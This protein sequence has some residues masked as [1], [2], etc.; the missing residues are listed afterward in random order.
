MNSVLQIFFFLFGVIV[1]AIWLLIVGQKMRW[2]WRF[3]PNV[4]IGF[5]VYL[6]GAELWSPGLIDKFSSQRQYSGVALDAV[7]YLHLSP[8]YVQLNHILAVTFLATLVMSL[9]YVLTHRSGE[10]K[11]HRIVTYAF[12]LT[13]ITF[14]SDQVGVVPQSQSKLWIFPLTV[15]VL[16]WLP[17]TSSL[18]LL[19]QMQRQFA[20]VVAA[21]LV[22]LV[23]YPHW[24]MAILYNHPASISVSSLAHRSIRFQG[25]TGHPNTMGEIG[26]LGALLSSR[27]PTLRLRKIQILMFVVAV[28]LSG[29]HTSMFALVAGFAVLWAY[30]PT[31]GSKV[32]IRTLGTL[33]LIT[34]SSIAA[35]LIGGVSIFGSLNNRTVVWAQTLDSWKLNPW[36]GYGPT[37]WSPAYRARFNLNSLGWAGMAHDQFIQSLGLAG[38]FGLVAMIAFTYARAQYGWRTR[39]RDRGLR[40]ALV[41]AL[42]ISMITEVPFS[43]TVPI[44][45]MVG[46]MIIVILALAGDDDDSSLLPDGQLLP[47]GILESRSVRTN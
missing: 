17:R 10:Q 26:V 44:F 11:S 4:L 37:L 43:I 29:S 46:P 1:L 14:I 24:A 5:F 6:S 33:V 31:R 9:G 8:R 18:W 30:G 34:A 7:A 35:T 28:A 12:I 36:F 3:G 39:E 15:A 16:Y 19:L 38:I 21:S 2:R 20:I 32:R 45:S 27:V 47:N 40:L 23:V 42:L 25:W 13:I 22:F 41:S